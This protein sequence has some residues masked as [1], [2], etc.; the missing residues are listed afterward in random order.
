MSILRCILEQ[1]K[2]QWSL[3]I[4]RWIFGRNWEFDEALVFWFEISEEIENSM[5]VYYFGNFFWEKLEIENIIDF[6]AHVG[7]REHSHAGA[8]RWCGIRAQGVGA[9]IFDATLV[10]GDAC[11]HTPIGWAARA[12]ALFPFANHAYWPPRKPH[13]HLGPRW[14]RWMPHAACMHASHATVRGLRQVLAWI[15]GSENKHW[16]AINLSTESCSISLGKVYT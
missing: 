13:A 15:N 6:H 3:S 7:R 10:C 12:G 5:K 1:L 9:Q 4:L 14:L 8:A 2:I 16:K 11:T